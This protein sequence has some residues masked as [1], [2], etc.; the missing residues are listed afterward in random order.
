MIRTGLDSGDI[1]LL[2]ISGK[3]DHIGTVESRTSDGL[4]I[5]IKDDLNE[6]R[7]FHFH[8]CQSLVLSDDDDVS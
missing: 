1:V 8:D 2:R 4:I 7:L 5:W 3:G 6:R